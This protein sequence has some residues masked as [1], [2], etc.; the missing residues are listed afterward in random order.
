L[1]KI[2][3]DIEDAKCPWLVCKALELVS[4][5]QKQIL[6][7]HYGKHEAEGAQNVEELYK[8]LQ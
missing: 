3:T 1:G 4:E 2:G 6:V 8:E 7:D 5:D